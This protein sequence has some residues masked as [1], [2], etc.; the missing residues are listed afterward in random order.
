MY[1]YMYMYVYVQT[2]IDIAMQMIRNDPP[3]QAGRARTFE[4]CR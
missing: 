4:P 1:M 3:S 2:G